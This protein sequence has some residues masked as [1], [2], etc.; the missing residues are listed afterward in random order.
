[1]GMM[2]DGA[3]TD[4][5]F[6]PNHKDG[7]FD[8]QPV[9]FR[10]WIRADGSS[11][12]APESGRYHLYVSYACPWAHR[13]LI[14]RALK[15]LQDHISVTVVDPLMLGKGWTYEGNCL[16]EVYR[17]ARNDFTGRVTV[18]VLWDTKSKTIVNNESSE[19][20]RMFNSEL[21]G[22]A[23]VPDD[24]FWP[25]DKRDAIE[26]IN[27]PI[28]DHINNGVYKCG[29]AGTQ[30]AYN[31]AVTALFE[32][33]D[34]VER[35]L[36]ETRYLCGDSITEADWRL[37]TTLLRFDTVYATHFK[38]NKRR[39]CD[40]DNLWNYTRELYQVPGVAETVNLGHIKDHY[41]QSHTSINPTQI[42]PVGFEVDFSTP[43][44]RSIP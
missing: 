43:W 39:L 16:Y 25:E 37:L 15:K 26:Q 31:K 14:F 29:F 18:P 38:C 33:L 11:A 7:H 10:D 2:V 24:D 6:V 40:Y 19:I 36:A 28:Y 5:N 22:L 21:N 30:A 13:T 32:T 20:I 17:A 35:R 41:F 27:A 42:V 12:Y 23:G 1:M 9:T 34:M 8:R 4:E 44:T 3:W